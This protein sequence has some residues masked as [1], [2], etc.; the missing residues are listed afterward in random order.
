LK[1]ERSIRAKNFFA[2]GYGPVTGSKIIIENIADI[3]AFE[4]AYDEY[5][6]NRID[7][8]DG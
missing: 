3:D 2:H 8:S 4:E 1:E 6:A 5:Q 7:T